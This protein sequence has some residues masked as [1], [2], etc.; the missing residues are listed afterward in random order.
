MLKAIFMATLRENEKKTTGTQ[1]AGSPPVD[2]SVPENR[3][4]AKPKL[5][6]PD[7]FFDEF[8][9]R[10]DVDELMRRLAD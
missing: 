9:S 8:T 2:Q 4:V 1:T 7:K 6:P 3:A 10:P 5:L